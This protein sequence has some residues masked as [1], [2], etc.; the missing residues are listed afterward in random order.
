MFRV[1][2]RWP[3]LLA[4]LLLIV[5]SISGAALSIFPAGESISSPQAD[6]TLT[7]ADLAARV[8]PPAHLELTAEQVRAREDYADRLLSGW[9]ARTYAHKHDVR[10]APAKRPQGQPAYRPA[11][12]F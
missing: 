1:I 5:L 11:V 7:I 2:H 12:P 9:V 3:G 8:L 6:V 4:A 10:F